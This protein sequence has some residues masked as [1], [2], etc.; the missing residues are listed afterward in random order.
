MA[1]YR[2]L[3]EHEPSLR[4]KAKPVPKITPN[5]LKLLDNLAETMYS[6][7]GVGLAAPQ[8]GVPKR[9]FVADIGDQLYELINPVFLRLSEEAASENEGCLSVPEKYGLVTR[10]LSVVLEGQNRLGETVTIATEGYLARVFQHESDHL[11]GIL[12]TDI[13]DAVYLRDYE[14]D[15]EDNEDEDD[16]DMSGGADMPGDIGEDRL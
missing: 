2:I 3:E 13:A 9:V 7:G 6:A 14:D 4:E 12:F 5:V 11:N 15:D 16:D 1:V 8:I 10:P